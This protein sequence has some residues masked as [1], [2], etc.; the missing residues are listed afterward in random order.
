MAQNL[1][2]QIATERLLEAEAQA[3]IEGAVLYPNSQRCC[4][5]HAGR[6]EQGGHFRG[7]RR[8]ERRQHHASSVANGSS[9][10]PGGGAFSGATI[11]P[12]DLY[13]YGLQATYDVDLWGKN[14]RAVEAA[15]AAAASSQEA[16][17]AA[18]LN[19]QA[20]VASNYIQLRGTEDGADHHPAE[21]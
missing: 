20:Q 11:A 12:L 13:Q 14:R 21:S 5:L 6:A 19:V 4:L 8:R 18:L 15:V 3:Q 16:R 1:D 10:A 2:L 17:R 9:T 7:L